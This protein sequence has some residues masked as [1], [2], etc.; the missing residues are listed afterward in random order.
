MVH[1][2]VWSRLPALIAL[3]V[4]KAAAKKR[5]YMTAMESSSDGL[6]AARHDLAV[7]GRRILLGCR[8]ALWS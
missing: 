2:Q 8:T 3:G 5:A 1:T 4:P 7:V 6:S